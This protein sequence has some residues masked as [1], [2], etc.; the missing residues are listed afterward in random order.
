MD[1]KVILI[2]GP[3]S[4]GKTYL[5]VKLAEKLRTEI[6]SADSRQIYKYLDIGTAKPSEAI[7]KK[8]KHHFI[9]ELEPDEDYN[10]SRFEK[11]ALGRIETIHKKNKTPIVAGGSGLYIKAVVDGIIDEAEVDEEYRKR[12]IELKNEKGNQYI[13]NLLKEKDIKASSTMLPSNWKRVIRALE[14][15]HLT[16]KSI[17]EFHLEQNRNVNLQ[18]FQFGLKWKREKL[19]ENIE[20]RVDEMIENGLVDETKNILETGYSKELNSLNSVGYK[21]IIA[22]LE[23]RISL[24]RAVELIKRNTRRY[25]KRQMTWFRRDNRIDWININSL[26]DLDYS[27]K[28]ILSKTG[29]V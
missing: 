10:V 28:Y 24:E 7:L 27:V 11:E 21:E 17:T 15:L 4:S 14:V 26:N 2:V 3:T 23:N 12:L 20:A 8:I 25:A 16:G 1:G 5:A 13:Y 19:Y 29:S 18:F 22:Y 9:N 6:L